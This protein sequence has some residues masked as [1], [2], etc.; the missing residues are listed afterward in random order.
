MAKEQTIQRSITKYLEKQGAWVTKVI[1]ANKSGVPDVLAC[2]PIEI[3][4]DM[5]GQRLGVFVGC[6]VK[7]PKGVVSPVQEYNIK[8]IRDAGGIA[9]VARSVEDV[10]EHFGKSL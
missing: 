9:F 5:V 1:T 4:A 10:I 2:L 7:M 6:E 3:T 8:K